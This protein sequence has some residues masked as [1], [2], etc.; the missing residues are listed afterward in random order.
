MPSTAQLAYLPMPALRHGRK[1][2]IGPNNRV[3]VSMRESSVLLYDGFARKKPVT[4]ATVHQVH[5]GGK[6]CGICVTP[7]NSWITGDTKLGVLKIRTPEQVSRIDTPVSHADVLYGDRSTVKMPES[8]AMLPGGLYASC[9][10]ALNEVHM[11]CVS[12][13]TNWTLAGHAASGFADGT[14]D[15][16][17]FNAPKGL[18]VLPNG[19]VLVADTGNN[20]LRRITLDGEVT[21]LALVVGPGEK[22]LL[23]PTD[24]AVDIHGVIVVADSGNHR[25]CMV[26]DNVIQTLGMPFAPA[27]APV[28]VALDQSGFILGVP[29]SAE[30]VLVK[31]TSEHV[32]P[33]LASFAEGA[34]R[35]HTDIFSR[36]TVDL[37]A[38]DVDSF[39]K[40]NR[41]LLLST[42]EKRTT[43]EQRITNL[44]LHVARLKA[45][46]RSLF[47]EDARDVE[48][49]QN[50]YAKPSEQDT[51]MSDAD[52]CADED[53]TD[54]HAFICPITLSVMVD[55]VVAKDENTYERNAIER[56]FEKNDRYPMTNMRASGPDARSVVSNRP[57]AAILKDQRESKRRRLYEAV[58]DGELL[59]YRDQ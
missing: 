55:P 40:Q 33:G 42:E 36:L 23:A 24:V 29:R 43:L 7:D 31:M 27:M 52:E 6:I 16:A 3:H 12:T 1:I 22:P 4:V 45:R 48:H 25:L 39:H 2:A 35:S 57:L 5:T 20:A 19:D 47:E 32:G 9:D 8:I 37:V 34:R 46:A 26:R 54:T 21:T 30:G 51:S 11:L 17:R 38:R 41:T 14:T 15:A 56:W 50:A 18:A 13:N 44:D 53:D 28:A 58:E 59:A 49:W 10:S